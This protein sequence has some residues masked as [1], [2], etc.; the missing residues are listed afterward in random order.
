MNRVDAVLR[1]RLRIALSRRH[2]RRRVGKDQATGTRLR[3]R[4]HEARDAVA[5]AA[6]AAGRI[7]IREG[8][9]EIAHEDERC[10]VARRHVFHEREGIRDADAAV[11]RDLAR[12]RD[13]R[14]VGRRIAERNLDLD[15]IDAG[16][17]HALDE[18]P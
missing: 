16:H 18:L 9:V 2:L 17:R 7:T 14:T 5:A 15:D 8:D 10:L 13:H 6:T 4:R 3:R 1:A 12:V 11:E